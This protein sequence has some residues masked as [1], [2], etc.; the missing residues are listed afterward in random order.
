MFTFCRVQKNETNVAGSFDNDMKNVA[1]VEVV[2]PYTVKIVTKAVEPLLPEILG[3]IAILSDSIVPHGTISYDL[4]NNCGVTGKWPVADDFNNGKAAVGTGPF[5]LAEFTKGAKIVLA[6]NANYPGPAPAW[7]KVTMIPVPAAGPRLAGLLAG[8]YDFIES[9]SARDIPRLKEKFGYTVRESSR[10]VFLQPDVGRPESPFVKA[11]NGKNPFADKRVREAMSLAID[12]DTIVKR[13]MDGFATPAYQFAPN[14]MFGSD[15]RVEKLEYNPEKAKKLL[16]E[17]G[18]PDGF[19]VTFA[20]TND[21][22][23]NDAQVSQAV[24]QYLTRVGIRT[25]L[26]SMTRSIFFTRRT[27]REFSLSMGGWGNGFGGAASFL[28]Q[29]AAST[30]K[31][32]GVGGSNYG[33]WDNAEFNAL[34]LQAIRTVDESGRRT[35]VEQASHLAAQEL[36]FIPLHFESSLW[37]YRKGLRYEGRMD[38]YTLADEILPAR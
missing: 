37:A 23:I 33:A 27:A 9:P 26:D 7:D 14:G 17:A 34:I 11:A 38:Q 2:D 22:Y 8:D 10:V 31:A 25:E 3:G 6:R 5:Q 29:Y 20:A 35:L 13:V 18:Y 15:P 4:A 30:D 32:A 36:G 16:A 1:S 19:S 24:T 12:R 28:R 21:R